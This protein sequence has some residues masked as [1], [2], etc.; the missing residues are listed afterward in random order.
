MGSIERTPGQPPDGPKPK[1]S[2]LQT[3]EQLE[4]IAKRTKTVGGK[5]TDEEW[6]AWQAMQRGEKPE[7]TRDTLPAPGISSPE[8][9]R[10]LFRWPAEQ[11][12]MMREMG[13][14]APQGLKPDARDNFQVLLVS[15]HEEKTP[16]SEDARR[17]ADFFDPELPLELPEELVPALHRVLDAIGDQ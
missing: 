14:H 15:L 11:K 1:P 17:L 13:V 12:S 6:A 5:L 10:R 9:V 2:R 4:E 7:T 8:D 3:R 16:L